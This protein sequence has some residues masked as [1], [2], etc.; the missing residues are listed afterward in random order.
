MNN[1]VCYFEIPVTD[2][3][4]AIAFYNAVFSYQFERANIDG[5]EMALFPALDKASGIT[6]ALAKGDSY[7]PG[8][9]GS[10]IYFSVVS[11]EEVLQKVKLAGG[12]VLYPETSVGAYGSVAEFE[13]SEGNCIALHSAK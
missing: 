4:R 13:D 3:E 7:V 9:Q 8:K 11:I 10:R 5:N 6:G 2:L 1:P 12:K